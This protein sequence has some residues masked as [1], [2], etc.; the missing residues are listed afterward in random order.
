MKRTYV[1]S[2]VLIAAARG[3]GK[4]AE[5]ALSVISDR[6]GREFVCSDYVRL[7]L[8]PKPTY[9]KRLAEVKF[10]E[11]FFATVSTWLPFNASDLDD[12]L[13]EACSVGMQG[14]DAVHV[15]VAAA[16]G[17]EEIVTSEKPTSALHRTKRIHVISI[18]LD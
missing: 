5:R 9:F 3:K 10:Y 15:V 17:C 13:Q 16:S 11:D 14:M 12:G 18:D 7:E 8:L 1:D 6:E 2:G 4:L